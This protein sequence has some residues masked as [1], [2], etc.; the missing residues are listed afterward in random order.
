MRWTGLLVLA[1]AAMSWPVAAQRPPA[2][3]TPTGKWTVEYADRQCLASRTFVRDGQSLAVVLAPTPASDLGELWL[4]TDDPRLA[5]GRT[6][7][8]TGGA[9]IE[10]KGMTL[11]GL[12]ASKQRVWRAGLQGEELQRLWAKGRL[13]IQSSK[14]V[15]AMA[16]PALA[17]VRGALRDCMEGLLKEWGFPASTARLTRYATPQKKVMAYV[18]PEDYPSAAIQE[19][20]SGTSEIMVTVGLDGRAKDCR[21]L[22]SAGHQA[23]DATTCAI[24]VRR[25]R[26][27]PALDA[28]GKAVEASFITRMTWQVYYGRPAQP[29]SAT[30]SWWAPLRPRWLS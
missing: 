9:A 4:L 6:Q 2:V 5:L 16:L 28:S 27:E 25:A 30:V 17:S 29:Y 21:V 3:W 14:L 11:T 13:D 15:A 18:T 22:K 8:Q 20:A 10:A 24:L 19:G 26:F 12:T 1:A 7:I 23:L